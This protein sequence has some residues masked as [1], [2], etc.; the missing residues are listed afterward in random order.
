MQQYLNMMRHVRDNGA[1]KEDRTGGDLDVALDDEEE[2]DRLARAR[3]VP[4]PAGAYGK[5]VAK[6][7]A[8]LKVAPHPSFE[9]WVKIL[10]G[11][12]LKESEA[13]PASASGD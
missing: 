2:Q 8:K 4:I 13:N 12:L 10:K 9:S 6:P 5:F 7:G 11:R 1:H 3:W